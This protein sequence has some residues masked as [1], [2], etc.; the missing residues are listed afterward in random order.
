M[1]DCALAEVTGLALHEGILYACDR[2]NSRIVRLSADDLR[3]L[4]VLYPQLAD[5]EFVFDIGA[6]AIGDSMLLCSDGRRLHGFTLASPDLSNAHGFTIEMDAP[7]T[8]IAIGPAGHCFVG[9]DDD[10]DARVVEYDLAFVLAD[11]DHSDYCPCKYSLSTGAPRGVAFDGG[12]L[13]VATKAGQIEAFKVGHG[14]G[15]G[16]SGTSSSHRVVAPTSDAKA[17]PKTHHRPPPAAVASAAPAPAVPVPAP[18]PAPPT[19]VNDVAEARAALVAAQEAEEEVLR[20]LSQARD[21]RRAREADLVAA[22]REHKRRK[23]EN[24]RAE[25]AAKAA[26]AAEAELKAAEM[27]AEAER[28]RAAAERARAAALHD[29]ETDE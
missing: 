13:H 2:T 24:K 22:E 19:P 17:L 20:M 5:G 23:Q 15:M 1:G 9:L 4:D 14:N 12:S 28:A 29:S 11:L 3:V 21:R 25:A 6:I 8:G 27:Q 18:V 26:E 10:N 7:I 16:Q